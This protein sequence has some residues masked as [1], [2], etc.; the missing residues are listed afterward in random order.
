MIVLGLDGL[1]FTYCRDHDFKHLLLKHHGRI[2]VPIHPVKGVP[3]SPSVWYSFLTGEWRGDLEFSQPLKLR[4]L[5]RVRKYV[6][7]SL[8]L[9]RKTAGHFRYPPMNIDGS[10]IFHGWR[11]FNVPYVNLDLVDIEEILKLPRDDLMASQLIRILMEQRHTFLQMV[12]G[13]SWV[14]GYFQFPDYI[15]HLMKE[16]LIYQCYTIL[17]YFVNEILRVDPYVTIVSDHGWS[18]LT[19]NHSMFGM[20]SSTIAFDPTPRRITE[21]HTIFHQMI[22]REKNG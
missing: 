9:G 17:D 16:A 10:F 19:D 11:A 7:I 21:F 4:I 22:R 15:Q 12:N 14:M 2:E 3:L 18:R 8:G 20:Y 5:K 1:D 6:P 13:S